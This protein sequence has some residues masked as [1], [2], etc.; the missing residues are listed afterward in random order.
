MF[1]GNE[2]EILDGCK[3]GNRIAQKQ[4]FDLFSQKFFV[5]CL[6]YSAN[7]D[8]A[9]DLLQEGFIKIF[10]NLGSY[11]EKGSF[12]GWMRKIMVNN[13]LENIRRNSGFNFSSEP[14][15]NAIDVA[16]MPDFSK[17]ETKTILSKIQQLAPGFRAI[18]NLYIIE[19]YQ[20]HEI[21]AMMGISEGTSKSQLSR[22]RKILQDKLLKE[23][24]YYQNG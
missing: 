22:A 12:E 3:Q 23:E 13:A 2:R 10:Q 5:L 17:L 15:D 19:G 7:E 8:E 9:K 4:L 14:Q 16:V 20:H 6:R 24:A 1:K 18:L 11:K 21:A